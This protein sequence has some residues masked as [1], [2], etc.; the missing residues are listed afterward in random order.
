MSNN[1]IF[2][3]NCETGQIKK[4]CLFKEEVTLTFEDLNPKIIYEKIWKE[5]KDLVEEKLKE[6][7]LKGYPIFRFKVGKHLGQPEERIWSMYFSIDVEELRHT[8]YADSVQKWVDSGIIRFYDSK[9]MGSGYQ[10]A[11]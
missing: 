4:N 3:Q 8:T 5:T 11:H 6:Y 10:Y 1:A 7:F 2:Y 9:S